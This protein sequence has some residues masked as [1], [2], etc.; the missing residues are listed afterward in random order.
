[1]P[2]SAISG[3]N[4]ARKADDPRLKSWYG[5]D[6]ESLIDILDRLRLPQ[7]SYSRPLRVTISDYAPKQQGP[8]IGDCVAAK[9]E[10][11]VI[12]E[13]KDLLLMP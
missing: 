13:K 6:K 1:M 10:S 3:E 5:P 2:I 7:R 12:I 4:V 11:G 8:L 9:V